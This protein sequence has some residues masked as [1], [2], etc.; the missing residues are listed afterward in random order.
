MTSR[1]GLVALKL[2]LAEHDRHRLEETRRTLEHVVIQQALD[3]LERALHARYGAST[4]VRIRKLAM[5]WQLALDTIRDSGLASELA[6][7][8]IASIV[9]GVDALPRAHRL[10]PSPD[11][12]VVLF[13]DEAHAVAAELAD[14][15][16]ERTAWFHVDA[17]RSPAQTWNAVVARGQT[18]VAAVEQWLERMERRETVTTWIAAASRPQPRGQTGPQPLVVPTPR[19]DLDLA[20]REPVATPRT[21]GGETSPSAAREELDAA[22]RW[23]EPE[24]AA[25]NEAYTTTDFAG[26][27]YFARLVMDLDMAEQLWAAGLIE[28]DFLAHVARAIAGPAAADDASWRWFGGAWDHEP[29][30][31]PLPPWA[32]DELAAGRAAALSRVAPSTPA[33]DAACFAGADAVVAS[34]AAALVTAFCA[35]LGIAPD[36]DHTRTY[37]R[38]RGRL[39]LGDTLRVVMD[40]D[41]IDLDVRRAGLD[42]N[43]GHLPWLGRSL[44]LV[45]EA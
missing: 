2:R 43:P 24:L 39:E 1:V 4:I 34:A 35:R 15:S 18:Y 19:L 29:Q 17:T 9:A 8:L 22:P 7:D 37:L 31:A 5:R 27:W 14:R 21:V 42:V 12:N 13:A 6:R 10:R 20:G 32:I 41:A 44:E 40:M 38:R 3:E 30:I 45:F 25:R 23:L 36:L 33:L 28:G 11:A 16:E 26:L